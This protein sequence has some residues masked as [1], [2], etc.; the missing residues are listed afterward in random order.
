MPWN[1]G[2]LLKYLVSDIRLTTVLPRDAMQA[3]PMLS[4]GVCLSVCVSVTFVHFVKTN[5][6]VFKFFSP[7]GSHTILVFPLQTSWRYSEGDPPNGGVECRWGRQKSD[8]KPIPGLMACFE[9]EVQYTY[10]RQTSELMTLVADGRRS[11]FLTG[12]DDTVYEKKPQ[13][14][15]EDNRAAFNCTLW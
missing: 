9:R 4:C 11:L 15:A 8:S 12:D 13:C 6:H 7:S 10:P 2:I 1:I 5:K 14:Y 3:R